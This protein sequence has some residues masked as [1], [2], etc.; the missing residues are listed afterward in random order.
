MCV[1]R[2]VLAIIITTYTYIYSYSFGGG[3]CFISVP[4]IF[5]MVFLSSR[6]A[7]RMRKFFCFCHRTRSKS[8]RTPRLSMRYGTKNRP[9][10]GTRGLQCVRMPPKV[11]PR[12]TVIYIYI[13]RYARFANRLWYNNSYCFYATVVYIFYVVLKCVCKKF[14]INV[15]FS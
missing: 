12:P 2:V 15:S 8:K 7:G 4:S 11:I 5:K 3:M 1:T 9:R 13:Y 6:F 10:P 14:N